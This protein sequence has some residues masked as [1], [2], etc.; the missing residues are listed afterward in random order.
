MYLRP[1]LRVWELI[2]CSSSKEAS[3]LSSL[4]FSGYK[5][6]KNLMYVHEAAGLLEED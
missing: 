3:T 2:A 4:S 6:A 1:G 5:E